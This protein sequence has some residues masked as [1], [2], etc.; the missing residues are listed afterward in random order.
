MTTIYAVNSGVYDDMT[1]NALFSSVEAAEAF[2]KAVPSS[3]GYNELI[4][5]E[6]DP[7]TA[8]RLARGDKYW[9]VQMRKDDEVL[10]IKQIEP[11]TYWYSDKYEYQRFGGELILRAHLWATDA[12]EVINKFNAYRTQTILNGTW[13][14]MK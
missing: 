5:Y 8:D 1:V 6:L 11:S 4:R 7:D 14:E 10:Q 13:G 12:Q 3:D 9:F 2:M